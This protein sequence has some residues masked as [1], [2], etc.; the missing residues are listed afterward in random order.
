[1]D[2]GDSVLVVLEAGGTVV[3]EVVVADGTVVVVTDGT[4]VDVL[5]V[6]VLVVVDVVGTGTVVVGTGTLFGQYREGNPIWSRRSPTH[7]KC[8][9]SVGQK[10]PPHAKPHLR[11]MRTTSQSITGVF[12]CAF[13]TV[14]MS[15][16]M[17]NA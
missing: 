7:S 16:A 6:D 14:F 11:K 3:G 5:V 13:A 9:P 8:M 17:P 4:V 1:M 10:F 2:G 15:I 12:H